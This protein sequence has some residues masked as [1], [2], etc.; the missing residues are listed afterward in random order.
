[1]FRR[2]CHVRT[3]WASHLI[4][5]NWPFGESWRSRGVCARFLAYDRRMPLARPTTAI[6]LSLIALVPLSGCAGQQD[7]APAAPVPKAGAGTAPQAP[8]LFLS[9]SGSDAAPC[10]QSRPCRSLQRGY[11]RARPGQEVELAAGSYP[12]Q[13]IEADPRKRGAT[14]RVVFQP[15][16][17]AAV[18]V[19]RLALEPGAAH[20]EMRRLHFPDGWSAGS[21]EDGPPAVDIVMRD[22]SGRLFSIEHA[23]AVRVLGGSY[24]PSLDDTSQIKVTS[25][26]AGGAPARILIQGV[27][28]HDYTRSGSDIHTECLQV[29]AG[30]DITI[31][32][33]RFSNCDGTGGLA[34][35]TL[36]STRLRNVLVENNWFDAR[37]DAHFA[38]QA[39]E[40]VERLVLRYNSSAKSMVFTDC[41]KD[42]CGSARVVANV[43]PFGEGLCSSVATYSHNVLEGGACSKADLAVARLGF[44]DERGFDL[45]LTAGSPAICRGDPREFPAWDIDGDRRSRTR[46]PDAGADQVSSR[47]ARR[48]CA[49]G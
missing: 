5:R 49:V 37:G 29:Y 20:I 13:L 12:E 11:E 8:R 18:S 41:T 27:R 34:L 32:G 43:M 4:T 40:S 45:H 21:A 16:R 36:S 47:P 48:S 1:M 22:T 6:L 42:R 9:A 24:G 30:T 38:V 44:A 23:H 46:R 7:E 28:M 3:C 35:T 33:N 31:R 14:R 2:P 17:G 19:E 26:E 10:T 15:A 39:D 25:P